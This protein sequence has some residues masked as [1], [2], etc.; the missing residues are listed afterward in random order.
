M[1][2]GARNNH[3][4]ATTTAPTNISTV[5]SEP[6]YNQFS[7]RICDDN[8][9]HDGSNIKSSIRNGRVTKSTSANFHTV[10]H[11]KENMSKF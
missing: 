11:S 5:G 10:P 4:S 9:G 1:I 7:T 3:T 6:P 2:G 8:P